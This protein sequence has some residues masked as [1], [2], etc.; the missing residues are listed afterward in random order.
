MMDTDVMDEKLMRAAALLTEVAMQLD[1]STRTCQCCKLA[2]RIHPIEF[3]AR[4]SIDG[5]I[6]RIAKVREKLLSGDWKDRDELDLHD[7][8]TPASDAR[9]DG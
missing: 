3:L 1:D 8:S 5:A 2:R 4:Q 9:E 6:T 7:P